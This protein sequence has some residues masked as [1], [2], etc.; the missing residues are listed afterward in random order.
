MWR[1]LAVALIL[2]APLGVPAVAAARWSLRALLALIALG[3]L[4]TGLAHVLAATAAGRLGATR[5][6][7]TTFLM[8]VVALILGIAVRGEHVTAMSVAGAGVCL[9]GAW[10][11]RRAHARPVAEKVAA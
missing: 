4:G 9:T 2:T 7:A 11:I 6:S 3:A 8:P 10:I 5:A 1:A